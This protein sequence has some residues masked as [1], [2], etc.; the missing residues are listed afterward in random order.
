MR[1]ASVASMRMFWLQLGFLVLLSSAISL[2]Y[3]ASAHIHTQ[4][5]KGKNAGSR[6]RTEDGAYS[7]RDTGHYQDGEHHQEFDHEAIL[8]EFVLFLRYLHD[9]R[10]NQ[11]IFM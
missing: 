7:P 9:K 5:G 1:L 2:C 6:E 3:A 10:T 8:G 4:H 11:L